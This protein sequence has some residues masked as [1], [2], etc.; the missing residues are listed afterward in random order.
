M[1]AHWLCIQYCQEQNL[2]TCFIIQVLA[3]TYVTHFLRVRMSRAFPSLGRQSSVALWGL[4]LLLWWLGTLTLACCISPF[5]R[6][7][8]SHPPL[9]DV[10]L[11]AFPPLVFSPACWAGQLAATLQASACLIGWALFWN[12]EWRHL[13]HVLKSNSKSS[14]QVGGFIMIGRGCLLS[15]SHQLPRCKHLICLIGCALFRNS[16]WRFNWQGLPPAH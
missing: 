1:L 11:R 14:K 6:L 8:P 3:R 7:I 10:T 15:S 4:F 5:P 16:K 12:S 2:Q 13:L 9:L